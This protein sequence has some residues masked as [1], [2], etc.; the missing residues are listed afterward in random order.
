LRAGCIIAGGWLNAPEEKVREWTYYALYHFVAHWA[1]FNG[2]FGLLVTLGVV[3][4][5]EY[6]VDQSRGQYDFDLY[7][8]DGSVDAVEV[9]SSVDQL[10]E[11]TYARIR[12]RGPMVK[13]I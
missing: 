2:T 6:R 10:V 5:M 12:K 9:T 3:I 1:A 8:S 13:R 7:N 4:N 11:R